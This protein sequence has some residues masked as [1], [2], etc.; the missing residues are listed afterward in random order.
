MT[1][2]GRC[3]VVCGVAT[4][5][6]VLLSATR[7]DE[8]KPLLETDK[9]IDEV[10]PSSPANITKE[11]KSKRRVVPLR[12][13]S[14]KDLAALLEKHFQ[15]AAEIQA[16]PSNN[17]LLIAATPTVFDEVLETISQI[18]RRPGTVIVDVFLVD[19][20][21]PHEPA[22][23]KARVEKDWNDRD[24]SGPIEQ[25]TARLESLA[26]EKKIANFAQFR[27]ETL[28][29]RQGHTQTGGQKPMV[30]GFISNAA[31]GVN[32]PTLTTTSGGNDRPGD[33]ADCRGQQ[34]AAR[35]R[36]S[37]RPHRIPGRWDR[38]S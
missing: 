22:G 38:F 15:G 14:A 24:F 34:S 30:N 35:S 21:A 10:P 11:A 13:A 23:D 25:L 5:A 37:K 4:F 2:S 9:K 7:A 31:T 27:V 17:D 16:D 3:L 19:V 28:E 36:H 6:L 32:S 12:Y 26:K 1:H 29:G 20:V 8:P 18:D 33:S